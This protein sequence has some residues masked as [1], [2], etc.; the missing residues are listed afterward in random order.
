MILQQKI[1]RHSFLLSL[2]L[3]TLLSWNVMTGAGQDAGPKRGFQQGGSFALS[4][5][6]SINTT[7][8]NLMM[9]FPLASLPVGRNGLT[10]GINLIYNSKLYNTGTNWHQDLAAGGGKFGC[11]IEGCWYQT[12]GIGQSL[13]GG[14]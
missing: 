12:T 3:C 8:G 5:I 9:H 4:D 2:F 1:L 7:N 10:A 11:P 13:D 6:E 14:W